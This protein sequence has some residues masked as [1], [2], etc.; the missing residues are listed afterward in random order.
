MKELDKNTL[1]IQNKLLEI[2]RTKY[3][4]HYNDSNKK[5][6]NETNITISLTLI[7]KEY[8]TLTIVKISY[9]KTIKQYDTTITTLLEKELKALQEVI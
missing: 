5:I 9:L 2:A 1:T 6:F 8:N 3:I 7:S 4:E